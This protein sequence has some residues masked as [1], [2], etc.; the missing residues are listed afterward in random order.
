MLLLW[1]VGFVVVVVG[2]RLAGD[3]C[4]LA[5]RLIVKRL[6]SIG[7]RYRRSRCL[8]H[9][10]EAT[11]MTYFFEGGFVFLLALFLRPCRTQRGEELRIGN[12][13]CNST[14]TQ[15]AAAAATTAAAATASAAAAQLLKKLKANK[16]QL[17]I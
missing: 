12:I 15:T 10:L 3:G 2:C 13:R 6:E 1:A 5:I 4:G 14:R 7:S 17:E 9:T 8:L 16:V 11:T